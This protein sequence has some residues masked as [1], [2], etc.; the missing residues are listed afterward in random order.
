MPILVQLSIDVGLCELWMYPQ[1]PQILGR[2]I[3]LL[4]EDSEVVMEIG[5]LQENK[6]FM[7]PSLCSG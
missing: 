6:V 3:V 5:F 2:S 4:I 7:G 1:I